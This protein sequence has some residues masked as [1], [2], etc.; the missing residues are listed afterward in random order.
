MTREDLIIVWKIKSRIEAEKSRLFDLQIL[1]QSTTAFLDGMPHAK[2]LTFK[3]ERITTKILECENR[4]KQLADELIQAKCDLL[5]KL[6]SL[7]LD[8]IYLRV[9]K[10]HYVACFKFRQI[11]ELMHF[12]LPYVS[13]LHYRALKILGLQSPPTSK[14]KEEITGDL[15]QLKAT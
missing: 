10:Y 13:K 2:P 15:R 9:L 7:K 12:S 8:E 14:C 5:E 6:Q 4:L 3:I 1:S 11:A